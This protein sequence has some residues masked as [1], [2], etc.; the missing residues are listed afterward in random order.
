MISVKALL[1]AKKRELYTIGAGDSVRAALLI[2]AER[3]IGALVVMDGD[4]LVGILSERD[5]AIKGALN[6]NGVDGTKVGDIM[7]RSVVTVAPS[8]SLEACMQ[9][10]TDRDIRHLPVVDGN[11]VVGMVSIGDV[12]KEY[13]KEQLDLIGQ[14]ETYVRRG[15]RL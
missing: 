9:Q 15:F 2:L 11:K 10:M 1:E 7:T 12:S 13:V 4:K 3:N 5:C 8:E 14:L 6:G